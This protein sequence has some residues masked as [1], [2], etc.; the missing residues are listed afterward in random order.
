MQGRKTTYHK[1]VEKWLNQVQK[2]EQR[3]YAKI[4]ALIPK[5]AKEGE[6]I[7]DVD[8]RHFKKLQIKNPPHP[9][10]IIQI[11]IVTKK[12]RLHCLLTTNYLHI[13]HAFHKESN[14]TPKSQMDVTISRA[15]SIT[16]F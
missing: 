8:K 4:V 10:P 7:M 11:K 12:H 15:K 13:L 6:A 2:K 14:K 9:H 1:K 5:L 3:E 16:K